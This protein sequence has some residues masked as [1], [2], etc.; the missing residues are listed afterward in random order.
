MSK[1][2]FSLF[3]VFYFFVLSADNVLSNY[4]T[5]LYFKET[6]KY[7][8]IKYYSAK[9]F[10]GSEYKA[11]LD[12]YGF[13]LEKIDDSTFIIDF[14]YQLKNRD[15]P[16]PFFYYKDFEMIPYRLLIYTQNL[17]EFTHKGFIVEETSNLEKIAKSSIDLISLFLIEESFKNR[18][19][20]LVSYA[21]ENLRLIA[22]EFNTNQ[23]YTNSKVIPTFFLTISNF[24][25]LDSEDFLPATI[26][27]KNRTLPN[28]VNFEILYLIPK[29]EII[30]RKE[31]RLAK[32][33][34]L[35]EQ[36]IF[37]EQQRYQAIVKEKLEKERLA[38]IETER[39]EKERLA[40]IEVERK[41][42]E[43][44][45]QI[46]AERKE[47]ERLAQIEA[48]RKEKER[49][50]QIE[51][52][53]KEKER[54]AQIEAERKEKERLAQIEVERKEKERLAQIEAERKEK[55]RLAQ[56]EAERIEKERLAQIEAERKEKE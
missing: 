47:K 55:E 26:S 23:L 25:N 42:K 2:V 15:N 30:K 39:I 32:K 51:A 49:L 14:F 40:Q 52:E 12:S 36:K 37:E 4:D 13:T 34:H 3:G 8:S 18:E 28:S 53:R 44:L 19:N 56:I 31:N 21:E 11:Q 27:L 17:Q 33:K 7:G 22:L 41:E 35:Q 43:R 29:N 54:L 9:E 45:A 48:E 1:I 6:N 16:T 5:S 46:E 20:N 24:E 50:A 10:A 38:Q